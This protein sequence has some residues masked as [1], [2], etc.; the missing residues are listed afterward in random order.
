MLYVDDLVLISDWESVQSKK[1][2]L[3][4]RFQMS[5]LGPLSYFIGIAVT[6]DENGLHLSEE[7]YADEILRRFQFSSSH[8]GSTPISQGTNLRTV[9]GAL[10][11]QPDATIYRSI[12]GSIM[13]LMLA[14]MPGLSYGVGAVSQFSSASSMDHLPALHHILRYI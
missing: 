11:S 3:N 8:P 9:S 10:L 6:Q 13:D 4:I 12:I 5:D 2:K 7:R 1:K 14:T